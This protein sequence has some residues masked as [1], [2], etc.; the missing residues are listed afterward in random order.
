M[1]ATI[2]LNDRLI[3]KAKRLSGISDEKELVNMA[4]K[5][6]IKGEE[7]WRDMVK[8]KDSNCVIE[9]YDPKGTGA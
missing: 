4:I 9:G 8:L 6:Y 7:T 2:E 1:T 3:N 5:S